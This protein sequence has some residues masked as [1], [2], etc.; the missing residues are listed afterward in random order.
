MQRGPGHKD[1]SASVAQTLEGGEVVEGPGIL[2]FSFTFFCSHLP[3][4][5]RIMFKFKHLDFGLRAGGGAD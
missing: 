4:K 5:P 2:V 3:A 1:A